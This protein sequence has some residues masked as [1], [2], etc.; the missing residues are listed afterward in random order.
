M[1]I[2]RNRTAPRVALAVATVLALAYTILVLGRPLMVATILAW[3]LTAYFAW[4]LLQLAGR[5]VRATERIAD[6]LEA[7]EG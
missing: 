4:R 6:A 5:L 3:I 7:H 2:E 1:S